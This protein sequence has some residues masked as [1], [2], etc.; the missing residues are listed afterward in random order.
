VSEE[1]VE[2]VRRVVAAWSDGGVEAILPFL[3]EDVVWYPFPEWIE[4][5]EYHGHDGVRRVTSVW[6]DNF[7]EYAI[8][9]NEIRDLG[10]RILMLGEQSGRLKGS[11]APIRQEMGWVVSDFRDGM[12]GVARFFLSWREAIDSAEGA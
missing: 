5:T 3:P 12:A 6:T 10:D 1:N 4:D 2:L 11:G 8:G 7:D 9:V